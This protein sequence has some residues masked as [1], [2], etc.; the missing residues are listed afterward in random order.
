MEDIKPFAMMLKCIRKGLG[1]TEGQFAEELGTTIK[2][3]SLYE[4][5]K[6]FPRDLKGFL[7]CLEEVIAKYTPGGDK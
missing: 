5:S 3:I 7:A 6:S 4:H 2:T 1:L